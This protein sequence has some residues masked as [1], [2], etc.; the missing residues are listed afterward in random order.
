ML[1]PSYGSCSFKLSP[2]TALRDADARQE[3]ILGQMCRPGRAM[4]HHT[5]GNLFRPLIQRARALRPEQPC[6][7]RRN[8]RRKNRVQQ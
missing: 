7:L 1:S 4:K 8:L 5:K 6:T 2:A 3:N